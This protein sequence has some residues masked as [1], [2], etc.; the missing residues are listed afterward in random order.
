MT[1]RSLEDSA[2]EYARLGLYVLPVWW[3]VDGHCACFAKTHCERSPG[4]H[5]ITA[6]GLNDAT[7][8]E[9][10]IRTWWRQ[11]PAANVAIAL[12]PSGLIAFDVDKP[13]DYRR[14]AAIES[15][16]GEMRTVRQRSGSGNL[17]VFAKAPPFAIRGQLD[18]ITLRGRNYVVAAPSMHISGG[19]Y[20]WEPG[21][22]PWEVQPIELPASLLERLRRPEARPAQSS[23]DVDTDEA[24]VKRAR[25]YLAEKTP[26]TSGQHGHDALFAAVCRAMHGFGLDDAIVRSLIVE[27]FNPRCSP[28]WS[29]CEIDHK[30]RQARMNASPEKWR[31]EDR[32]LPCITSRPE[33]SPRDLRRGGR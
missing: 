30:I 23:S 26:A 8:S 2:L 22:A 25:A 7:T 21:F 20:A 5:P 31:V 16:H 32:K 18:G 28:P 10:T 3:I 29:D 13:E 19:C 12:A 24:R 33:P 1:A 4:K 6:H 14:L 27:D 11:R 15:A 17:H 9:G